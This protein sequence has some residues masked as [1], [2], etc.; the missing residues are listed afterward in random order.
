MNIQH[1]IREAKRRKVNKVMIT[2]LVGSWLLL[3]VS[4]IVLPVFGFSDWVLR[5]VLFLI[6]FGS[7]LSFYISWHY[8][9][10]PVGLQRDGPALDEKVPEVLLFNGK[11]YMKFGV[12]GISGALC[13][14]VLA[15]ATYTEEALSMPSLEEPSD[16]SIAILPFKV[17]GNEQNDGTEILSEGIVSEILTHLSHIDDL[18]VISSTSSNQYKDSNKSLKEIAKELNVAHVLEGNISQNYDRIQVSARLIKTEKDKQIWASNIELDMGDIFEMQANIS[19]EIAHSLKGKISKYKQGIIERIPTDNLV[20]Y[21][22]FMQGKHYS[23]LRSKENLEKSEKHLLKALE[24]DSLY[25]DAMSTLAYV[26]TTFAYYGLRDKDTYF[27]KAKDLSHQA[28][29]I[30]EY[31]TNAYSNLGD[32]YRVEREWEK[33][34]SSFQ[35]ALEIN[36]NNATTRH[37]YGLFLGNIGKRKDRYVQQRIAVSLDPLSPIINAAYAQALNWNTE[38]YLGRKHLQKMEGMF[39]SFKFISYLYGKSYLIDR[40]YDKSIPYF[41]EMIEKDPGIGV[42]FGWLA[43]AYDKVGL[44]DNSK[45]VI[46]NLE[47]DHREYNE[48]KAIYFTSVSELDSAFHY[49]NLIFENNP[50]FLISMQGCPLYDNLKIDFR[51]Y[52]LLRK[53]NFD[54][55]DISDVNISK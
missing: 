48:A 4:A 42:S 28:L 14:F 45:S 12:L 21:E 32:I 25:S 52:E 3:Q 10:T 47:K 6:L 55:D 16:K 46:G 51:Y 44:T 8:R 20:A 18:V 19:Q 15:K 34:D 50:S 17:L 24:I 37:H 35:I 31:D 36:P 39:P 9:L 29:S 11:N 30:N 13:L 22:N 7:V 53:M 40:Q 54:F 38:T 43:A 41:K 5:G 27:Q 26:Y 33:A 49:L 2:Y 23:K 1:L